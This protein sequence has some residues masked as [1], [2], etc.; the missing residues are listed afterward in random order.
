MKKFAHS[1]SFMQNSVEKAQNDPLFEIMT[2]L[3]R[4][5]SASQQNK[6]QETVSQMPHNGQ[7]SKADILAALNGTPSP[8][9]HENNSFPQ[10]NDRYGHGDDFTD[11][12][13]CGYNKNAQNHNLND[14]N[15]GKKSVFSQFSQHK[16]QENGNFCKKSETDNGKS[17]KNCENRKLTPSFSSENKNDGED[18]WSPPPYY[19]P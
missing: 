13:K 16:T 18:Y 6:P 2:S 4:Q 12:D 5:N 15:S 1:G 10:E 19:L 3:L 17:C 14:S 7:S 9:K 11:S 8:E